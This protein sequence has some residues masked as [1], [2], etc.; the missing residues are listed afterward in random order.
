M[1]TGFRP[2]QLKLRSRCV[3]VMVVVTLQVGAAVVAAVDAAVPEDRRFDDVLVASGL[4]GPTDVA[5]AED[6]AFFVAEQRGV[7][8]Y[9]EAEK[10]GQARGKGGAVEVFD[11]RTHVHAFRD[12][13]LLS[14]ALHPDYPSVPWLY[15][16]YTY[17]APPG[18]EAPFWGSAGVSYDPCPTPPGPNESGCVVRGRLARLS[19]EADG[20]GNKLET[21]VD[22]RW[23]EQFPS[24]SMAGMVFGPDGAL[25][26]AA[27]EGAITNPSDWGQL[28]Q[29]YW[30]GSACGDPELEGGSLRAQ[31]AR[32]PGDPLGWSGAIV[33]LDDAGLAQPDNPLAGSPGGL[34][35][36]VAFGLRN[37]FRIAFDP[38]DAS[39]WIGDVGANRAEELDRIVDP[40]DNIVENFEWP[41][42]EGLLANPAFAAM[43]LC[44]SFPGG[45][46]GTATPPVWELDRFAPV[47]DGC[48][49]A[50]SRHA[51]SAV[52]FASS[53]AYPSDRRTL[54]VADWV[55][56]CVWAMPRGPD[57]LPQPTQREVV[58]RG[59]TVSLRPGP[60]GE[61]WRVDADA[62]E[63]RRLV[64]R[65]VFEDGFESG[66][67]S[68]WTI[69][70]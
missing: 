39:L 54:F 4:E 33:R 51:L 23:C 68:R 41:C 18:F 58:L 66:D 55:S 67:S 36:I 19:V 28:G 12:R 6:G 7:V 52:G 61:L 16:A 70:R 11:L 2:P 37:P 50:G 32:T 10:A 29:E 24:H 9:F 25:Y 8:W 27:G 60:N 57:G 20:L 31:D 49:L 38:V 14:I 59:P 35:A 42:R 63:I 43:P 48:G 34:D 47:E 3:G 69:S 53:A 21:L 5:I 15:L 45:P 1:A 22:G 65:M 56:Q 46:V 44:V 13:G 17:D 64:S 26:V 40:V 30:G 62:G